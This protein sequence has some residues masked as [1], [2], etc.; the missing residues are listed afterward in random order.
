MFVDFDPAHK[1][2]SRL[3]RPNLKIRS[4][5]L[6]CRPI[7]PVLVPPTYLFRCCFSLLLQQLPHFVS[8]S[9]AAVDV[10]ANCVVIFCVSPKKQQQKAEI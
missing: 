8:F 9:S 4:P 1:I 6:S 3:L 5:I 10:Y 7:Y 2:D